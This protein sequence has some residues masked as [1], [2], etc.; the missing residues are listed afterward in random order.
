MAFCIAVIFPQK[1]GLIHD[2]STKQ[3]YILQSCAKMG[4]LVFQK[5]TYLYNKEKKRCER[6]F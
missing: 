5:L 6:L 3:L 4:L 2:F 1:P